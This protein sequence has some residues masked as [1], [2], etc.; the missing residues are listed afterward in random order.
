[1]QTNTLVQL[2]G[3]NYRIVKT[4]VTGSSRGFSLL[5]FITVVSPN[6]IKAVQHLYKEAGI[7]EGRAL[8]IANI[9]QQDTAPYFVLFSLPKITLRADVIEFTG[10]PL[11]APSQQPGAPPLH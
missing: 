7:T 1:M 10:P 8:A 11:T 5:G 3:Q 9:A 4:N 6:Y 2:N